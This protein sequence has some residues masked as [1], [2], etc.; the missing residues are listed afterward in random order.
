MQCIIE[1]WCFKCDKLRKKRRPEQKN[2]EYY[3]QDRRSSE[4]TTNLFSFRLH[5]I[6]CVCLCV[7]VSVFLFGLFHVAS[8]LCT[9]HASGY[10]RCSGRSIRSYCTDCGARA[11]ASIWYYS[12]YLL[13]VTWM[14]YVWESWLRKATIQAQNNTIQN[15][16]CVQEQNL[17]GNIL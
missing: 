9:E 6:G 5:S 10:L 17:A 15:K 16:M 12:C 2:K 14:K 13:G 7:W 1:I 11:R 4:A 8:S 3:F